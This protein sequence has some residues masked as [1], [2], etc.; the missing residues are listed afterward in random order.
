VLREAHESRFA[1]HSGSIK[2]YMDLKE[3]YWW[4]NMKKEIIEF[5]AKYG[6]CQ[7]VSIK[8]S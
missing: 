4:P 5:V 2:M 1:I 6:V 3:F 8:N 7:Q